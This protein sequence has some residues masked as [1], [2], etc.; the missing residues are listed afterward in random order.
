M[1][2]YSDELP[3]RLF[4]CS[5]KQVLCIWSSH[6][7]PIISCL[8][9][10][11]NGC[12][13]GAS[14]LKLPSCPEKKRYLLVNIFSSYQLFRSTQNNKSGVCVTGQE[15]LIFHLDICYAISRSSTKVKII[16][17]V[18]GHRMFLFQLRTY[19]KMR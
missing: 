1:L 17:E 9:K 6:C 8:I 13:S 5:K 2:T 18:H 14:L 10:T 11:Q 12:L 3:A 15:V 19:T 16:G 7:N 4:V